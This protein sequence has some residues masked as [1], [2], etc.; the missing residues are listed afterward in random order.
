MKKVCLWIWLL[1]KRQIKNP[2]VIVFLLGMPLTAVIVMQI[3]EMNEAQLPRV[4]IVISNG[5][6]ISEKV[7]NQLTNGK[8]SME[9]YSASSYEDLREDV[10]TGAAECG[11]IF[12][13]QMTEKLKNDDYADMIVQ[14]QNG[15]DFVPSMAKEIVFSALFSVYAK[16]MAV[17]YVASSPIFDK[18]ADRAKQLVANSYDQYLSGAST[19][20]MKFSRLDMEDAAEVV[21]IGDTTGSFPVKGILAILVYLAGLFGCVQ[22]KMDEKKG[23]F[24][25]LPYGFRIA[26]RPLYALIPTVLF[27]I[28]AELTFFFSHTPN[29][30]AELWR[31][32]LYIVAIAAFSWI[33]NL[34][35]PSAR[36]MVSIIPVLL[37]ASLVLCP[38]FINVLTYVPAAKHL[39]RLLLPYYYLM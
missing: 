11:Y 8:Y 6:E 30:A 3:P 37:I 14:L 33:L 24:L 35:T 25:T 5:D 27:A 39:A 36:A 7:L 10:R 31:M 18:Y 13:S 23:V 15:T 34:V 16:D 38:V 21:S 2:A 17:E 9:F 22:W 19:F 1:L 4:G 26:S 32:P 28:S 12:H 20:Y 29:M